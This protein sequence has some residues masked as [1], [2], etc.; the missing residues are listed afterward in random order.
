MAQNASNQAAQ[1]R[2]IDA[3]QNPGRSL[4]PSFTKA[5]QEFNKAYKEEEGQVLQYRGTQAIRKMFDEVAKDPNPTGLSLDKYE[6]SSKDTINDIISNSDVSNK[7]VLK[8]YLEDVYE[9]GFS[10]LSHK[11]EEANRRYLDKQM[12]SQAVST[13][14]NMISANRDGKFDAGKEFFD[15][16]IKQISMVAADKGWDSQTL[17]NAIKSETELYQ[18]SMG[19][20]QYLNTPEG[21]KPELMA[22]I[23]KN[24]DNHVFLKGLNRV[25]QDRVIGNLQNFN[26]NYQGALE[27]QRYINYTNAEAKRTLG[28]LSPEDVN[29]AA[30]TMGPR[31]AAKLNSSIATQQTKINK[32]AALS[33][34]M[35]PVLDDA[36]QMSKYSNDQVNTVFQKILGVGAKNL[37]IDVNAMPLT[38]QA[39][40]AEGIKAPITSLSDKLSS[41]I[42]SKDP[43]VASE[44][45]ASYNKLSENNPVSMAKIDNDADKIAVL[46]KNLKQGG[47][48]E[49]EANLQAQ[50][51]ILELDDNK[52]IERSNRYDKLTGAQAGSNNLKDFKNLT[53]FATNLCDFSSGSRLPP[54]FG[55]VFKAQHQANFMSTGDW[56]TANEL[57]SRNIRRTYKETDINGFKEVMYLAPDLFNIYGS[58]GTPFI[59]NQMIEKA[60]YDFQQGKEA[61]DQGLS[62]VYYTIDKESLIEN[63]DDLMK[64]FYRGIVNV[65]KG[66]VT[67]KDRL[68]FP[69]YSEK[70]V[71][72]TRHSGANGKVTDTDKGYLMMS[73]DQK[74]GL[75]EDGGIT[76][77]Y[78]LEMQIGDNR[79][80][81]SDPTNPRVAL[82]FQPNVEAINNTANMTPEQ[83]KKEIDRINEEAALGKIDETKRRVRMNHFYKYGVLSGFVDEQ[84]RFKWPG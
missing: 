25:Q 36:V 71:G 65:Q 53:N 54:G 45:I 84:G 55:E 74:S 62:S 63:Q 8:R 61:F 39:Q 22:D 26:S 72:I 21:E 35:T 30:E 47:T 46:A 69:I 75:P 73:S 16:R 52:M 67:E 76:P 27:G 83:I 6:K 80:M 15:Q 43:R 13:S 56:N 23:R 66:E 14:E 20:Y 19:Q 34:E 58:D 51:A 41:G 2:G 59:R 17:E 4:W 42:K 77:N 37:G 70:R 18:E 33:A 11:V 48:Q 28:T 40:L 3:A 24:P 68:L 9:D 57:T 78:F 64:A 32:E 49:L 60:A 7:T 29:N 44:A 5:D 81:L 79:T 12:A 38:A 50:Q 10:K 31:Y 82:R 1:E